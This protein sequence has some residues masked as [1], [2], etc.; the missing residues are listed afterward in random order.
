NINIP[1]KCQGEWTHPQRAQ[2]AI[3]TYLNKVWKAADEVTKKA[4]SK[5]RRKA[6][7]LAEKQ[8]EANA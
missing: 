8:E 7:L 6:E 5:A 3:E 1:E 2:L 4:S